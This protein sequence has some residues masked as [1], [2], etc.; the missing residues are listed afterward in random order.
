[1]VDEATIADSILRLAAACGPGSSISPSEV[2]R[3]LAVEWRPL[4]GPVRRAAARLA[5]AGQI[6]ILRKGRPIPP[7]ALHG[8]I[9]LRIRPSIEPQPTDAPTGPS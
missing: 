5:A 3:D 1:M 9:R 4:L 2:A 8:V 7:E 6:D